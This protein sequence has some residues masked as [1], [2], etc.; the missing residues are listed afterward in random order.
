MDTLSDDEARYR[1]TVRTKNGT[2]DKSVM[3]D[4]P[5]DSSRAG[6]GMTVIRRR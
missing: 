6:F 4:K 3:D 1:N 5:G 2:L